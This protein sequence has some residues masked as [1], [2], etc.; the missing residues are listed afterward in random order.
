MSIQNN[1]H[2]NNKLCQIFTD[3]VYLLGI[4]FFGVY[5][6]LQTEVAIRRAFLDRRECVEENLKLRYN[7]DQEVSQKKTHIQFL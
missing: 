2:N 5:V 3:L 1:T 6:R 7:R 4:N